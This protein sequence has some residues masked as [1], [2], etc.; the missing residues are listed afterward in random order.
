M[1]FLE[2][3]LW[4]WKRLCSYHIQSCLGSWAL[5]LRHQSHA[6]RMWDM[7]CLL[8]CWTNWPNQGEIDIIEGVNLQTNDQ[9]TLH[10]SNGCSMSSVPT[11]SFTGKWGAGSN[12]Q[13]SDNCYISAPNQYDNQGCS[14]ISNTQN[15]GVPLNNENG[16]V[17]ATQWLPSTGVAV[18][19]FPRNN[20]P[21]D[22]TNNQP[23][24]NTWGLPYANF[25]FGGNCNSNHFSNMSIVI[26][27]TFCGSWAGPAFP[28]NCPQYGN[29]CNSYV[30]NNPSAF[31]DAY[32][33]VN[34]L[35]VYQ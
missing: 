5:Y 35:K 21:S 4:K 29:N 6:T 14:I 10:T 11:N 1:R 9:T 17:F 12:G 32:W 18:W 15:Y 27:L 7:A 30:Q 3:F 34:S 13:P 24:P 26:N 23:N 8:A 2:Y 28:A 19:F 31:A 33:S 22:I 20:I 16:G 25:Q